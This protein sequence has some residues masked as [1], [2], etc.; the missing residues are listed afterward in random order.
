VFVGVGVVAGVVVVVGVFAGVL[1]VVFVIGVLFV[2]GVG[3]AIFTCVVVGVGAGVVVA[4]TGVLNIAPT[5]LTVFIVTAHVP[6]PL[7]APVHPAK[8]WPVVGIAV[9]ATIVPVA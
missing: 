8:V 2:F 5:V 1:V 9:S 4:V 6:V 7:H 3:V